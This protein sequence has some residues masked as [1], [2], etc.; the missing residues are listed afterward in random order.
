MQPNTSQSHRRLRRVLVLG[1]ACLGFAAASVR[2]PA[3][4]VFSSNQIA[5]TV[6]FTNS[7]PAILALLG[8]P[9]DEGMTNVDINASSLPP[10]EPRT[11][12]TDL[13][14]ATGRLFS[15]YALTVDASPGGIQYQVV[16]RALLLGQSDYY[17]FTTKT[18]APVVVGN[19]PVTLDFAECAGAVNVRFRDA[20]GAPLTVDGGRIDAY[21]ST[22]S[23]VTGQRWITTPG[24][25]EVRLYLRGGETHQLGVYVN[26]GTNSYRDRIDY[27]FHTDVKVVCDGAVNVDVVFPSGGTLGRITGTAD[28][29]GEFELTVDGYDPINSADYS[30]VIANYGPFNTSRWG[31][32]PGTNFTVPSSGPF[33][34]SNVVPSTLDPASPG[35]VVSAQFVARTN[36]AIQ[37]FRTPALGSGAN[38][39]LVVTPGAS[40]NLSNTLVINPGYVSGP[41]RLQGPPEAPGQDSLLRGLLHASDFD[42][43]G[44]GIPDAIGIYG[45]YYSSVAFEGVDRRAAGATYTASYGYSY[46]DFDG[47]FNPGTS[48]FDGS[49]E[50]ILGGLR[51]ER[52]IWKPAGISLTAYSGTVANPADYYY[53]VF[54][55]QNR[56]T[57]DFEIGAGER[58][59]QDLGYCFSEVRLGFSSKEGTFYNPRVRFSNGTFVGTDFQGQ[60]ADYQVN[61]DAMFGWPNDYASASNHGE[62]VMLLPQGTYTLYPAVTPAGGAYSIAGLEPI[63]LT[64][65]CGQ[66]VT[67]ETCLQVVIDTP[68]CATNSEMLIAGHVRSCS[69]HV[70]QIRYRLN[71]GSP[72]PLCFDCGPDPVFAFTPTFLEECGET[73][74]TIE[75]TDEFGGLSSVTTSLRYD[76]QPPQIFCPDQIT[77]CDSPEGTVVEFG[78]ETSDN[79]FGNVTVD[80]VPPSGSFFPPG[81]TRVNCTATDGCGNKTSCGF[82]VT[83]GSSD[84]SIERA[85]IV[86][87]TCPGTLQG[88]QNVEGPYSDIPGAASPYCSPASDPRKF[89]RVRQ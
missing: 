29:L 70:T 74:I 10:A 37:I 31:A 57:N 22:A 47:S 51:G 66:R 43:D 25:S 72:V 24:V 16:P 39:A 67:L 61:L 13:L 2:L 3:Q 87:W 71:G 12:V 1:L 8:P 5:G 76:S 26:R 64:V 86:R 88:A 53:N 56:R 50:L 32:L 54:S 49:Y 23:T 40:I 48:T 17:Y 11:A 19:P 58:A 45:V 38:P 80:C 78:I 63:T 81:T 84:L 83:I 77:I 46:G 75:A 7:N 28:I 9:G 60:P 69:N 55:I 52:S 33:T 27:I 42:L 89:F 73:L 59:S 18:S 79:C 82:P 41:L 15:E 34:L 36:R 4:V 35:Y 85:V 20:G 14:P 30:T 6:R 65:G 68:L 62:V 21:N 44:D